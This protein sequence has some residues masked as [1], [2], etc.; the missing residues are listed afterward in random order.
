MRNQP[1]TSASEQK[2]ILLIEDNQD[3]RTATGDLLETLGYRVVTAKNA[4]KALAA[5]QEESF[6]LAMVNAY[7]A[8]GT[9]LDTVDTLRRQEADLPVLMMSGFGDD[10]ELRRRV[11]AGNLDFLAIPFSLESLRAKIREILAREPADIPILPPLPAGP[12]WTQRSRPWL[13][14]AALALAVGL[15]LQLQNRQPDLP[16]PDLGEIRRGHTIEQI[17][18][19]GEIDGPPKRLAWRGSPGA[20]RYRVSLSTLD[21]TILWLAET[22][23]TSIDLPDHVASRLNSSVKYFWRVEGLTRDFARTGTS[24]LIAFWSNPSGPTSK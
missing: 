22:R 17:E 2:A 23:G 18:P 11:L 8:E 20:A 16:A 1:A 3:L 13:A 5:A 10:L 19:E 12:G 24:P 7:P 15:T 21:E 9:G 4:H 14:A 6:D